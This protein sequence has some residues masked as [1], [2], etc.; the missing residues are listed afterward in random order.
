MDNFLSVLKR[1]SYSF[2]GDT[3]DS[4]LFKSGVVY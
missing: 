1:G 4:W 3:L 2:S